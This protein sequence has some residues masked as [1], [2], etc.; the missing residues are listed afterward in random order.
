MTH[1]HAF[2]VGAHWPVGRIPRFVSPAASVRVAIRICRLVYLSRVQSFR[3]VCTEK[4]GAA[5][6]LLFPPK[7][8]GAGCSRHPPFTLSFSVCTE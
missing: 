1:P 5:I 7:D 8:C 4:A 3:A 2:I 6:R